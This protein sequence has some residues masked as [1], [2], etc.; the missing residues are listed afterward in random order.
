MQATDLRA[1]SKRERE[2]SDSE[3]GASPDAPPPDPVESKKDRKNRLRRELRERKKIA[4]PFVERDP[5]LVAR[6]WEHIPFYKNQICTAGKDGGAEVLGKAPELSEA[7]DGRVYKDSLG[8]VVVYIHAH[9]ISYIISQ[10]EAGALAYELFIK[11]KMKGTGAK[12]RLL[13]LD[14]ATGKALAKP[15]GPLHPLHIFLADQHEYDPTGTF[16]V[17]K[18]KRFFFVLGDG[19]GVNMPDVCKERE[20]A[21]AEAVAHAKNLPNG[22]ECKCGEKDLSKFCFQFFNNQYI[23]KR[24]CYVCNKKRVNAQ[25]ASAV[26]TIDGKAII[27]A[28]SAIN[29][30]NKRKKKYPHLPIPKLDMDKVKPPFASL[31]SSLM[32]SF[33][34]LPCCVALGIQS[35]N[36]SLDK[37]IDALKFYIGTRSGSSSEAGSSSGDAGVDL[38]NISLTPNI[39]NGRANA[40]EAEKTALL[41]SFDS[42]EGAA[43]P[44]D[45]EHIDDVC[46]KMLDDLESQIGKTSGQARYSCEF[47]RAAAEAITIIVNNMKIDQNER[48]KKKGRAAMLELTEA[49]M[50]MLRRTVIYLLKEQKFRCAY[51]SIRLCP[52]KIHGFKMSVERIDDNIGYEVRENVCLVFYLFQAK[53]PLTQRTDEDGNEEF[54]NLTW[55]RDVFFKWGRD[56]FGDEM[57]FRFTD[58][59]IEERRKHEAA[60]AAAMV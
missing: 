21:M 6:P 7:N 25:N 45:D 52:A 20:V 57:R 13:I 28:T 47:H 9:G 60:I 18:R 49:D 16:R 2:E 10:I 50:P 53:G 38:R 3:D 1:T 8:K 26:K 55:S 24:D 30:Q 34:A 48:R 36:V 46:I 17:H 31:L 39:N 37:I 56:I 4:A 44:V 19:T 42:G 11:I 35:Y 41:D 58:L 23:L 27:L 32:I 59:P 29:S 43:A 12:D 40:T 15:D 54:S 14:P 33:L 51:S 5:V 22:R